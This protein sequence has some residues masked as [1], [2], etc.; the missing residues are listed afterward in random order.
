[1]SDTAKNE[2]IAKLSAELNRS[3]TAHHRNLTD[4]A[5]AMREDRGHFCQ[6]RKTIEAVFQRSWDA[7]KSEVL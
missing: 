3:Q 5:K 4:V 1:M 6:S 7:I 2:I